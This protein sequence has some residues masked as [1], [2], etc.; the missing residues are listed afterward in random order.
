MKTSGMQPTGER[1]RLGRSSALAR[2]CMALGLPLVLIAGLGPIAWELAHHRGRDGVAGYDYAITAPLSGYDDPRMQRRVGEADLAYVE[3]ATEVI[4]GAI[5][6]CLPT[7]A[8]TW[9][10]ELLTRL[11]PR[12]FPSAEGIVDP[13][14]LKCGF[15]SQVSTVLARILRAN[16]I[17]DAHP[18]GL[19]GHV[20]VEFSINGVG[21]VTDPD[22]GI[23]PWLTS[24]SQPAVTERTVRRVYGD[25]DA[26]RDRYPYLSDLVQLTADTASD[27]PSYDVPAM[28]ALA[29][30]QARAIAAVEEVRLW[31][32]AVGVGLLVVGMAALI[33]SRR[34][35]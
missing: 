13:V 27:T 34:G 35:A 19:D 9:S 21:Y 4:G 8:Q 30:T 25:H 11:E 16:G 31:T 17:P 26:L 14:A 6:H 5:Y 3:R 33:T 7:D 23:G 24:W 22:F 10:T 2:W 15:C 20:V 32:V 29:D 28:A 12:I 1:W 18:R